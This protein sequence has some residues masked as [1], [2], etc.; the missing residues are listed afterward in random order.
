MTNSDLIYLF[1]DGETTEVERDVLFKELANNNELQIEFQDALKLTKATEASNITITPPLALTGAIFTKAGLTQ[2]IGTTAI[3]GGAS[4]TG[5]FIKELIATLNTKFAVGIISAIMASV[6]S[7][8]LLSTFNS[9]DNTNNIAG[10]NNQNKNIPITKSVTNDNASVNSQANSVEPLSSIKND[11]ANLSL[12]EI[13]NLAYVK[14]LEANYQKA[15][16]NIGA[17]KNDLFSL[18]NKFENLLNENKNY[19]KEITEL[20]ANEK[21]LLANSENQKSDIQPENKVDNQNIAYQ[22]VLKIYETKRLNSLESNSNN[23]NIKIYNADNYPK[24]NLLDR[25]VQS[26]NLPDLITQL[27]LTDTKEAKLIV[28]YRGITGLEYFPQRI[29]ES[30]NSNRANNVGLS[31]LRKIDDN[32]YVGLSGGQEDFPIY[33]L[34]Q[35]EPNFQN[36]LF[37]GAGNIRYYPE[38]IKFENFTPYV[39]TS[40]GGTQLGLM[41]KSYL[42]ISWEPIKN[43]NLNIATEG[44]VMS[45]RNSGNWKPSGKLGLTYGISLKF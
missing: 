17:Y 28:E 18:K 4:I 21:I 33:I 14:D 30:N 23:E 41:S 12:S 29:I 7:I 35:N 2:V 38:F 32:T 43:V 39:E 20:K 37:W 3:V 13:K 10:N 25:N 8:T 44:S 22:N 31:V 34:K 26:A 15:M 1:I 27:L 42:G 6:A 45:Y 40:I 5:G 36:S 24:N 19:N 9:N 16:R 11:L